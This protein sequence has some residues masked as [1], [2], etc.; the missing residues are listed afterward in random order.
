MQGTG[1][2]FSR[3]NRIKVRKETMLEKIGLPPKPSSRGNNW[4]VDASHCQGCSSLF[5]FINRKHHCRRCGGIF[6]NSCTQQRMVL[7][8]QGDSPVRICE[9]CKKLEEAARFEMRY[10]HKNRAGRGSSK[11]TMKHEDDDADQV[12]GS[13]IMGSSSARRREIHRSQSIEEIRNIQNEV[14]SV[15]PEELR[16]KAL[17]EKKKYKVLKGEGKSDEALKTFKRGKELERQ[18]EALEIA[19]RKN[20]KRALTSGSMAE[21]QNKDKESGRRSKLFP[22]VGKEKDDFA[23]ELR[24]LGWSDM[25]IHDEAKKPASSCLEGELSS[26][27]GEVSQRT[28]KNIGHHGIDNSQVVAHKKKALTLKREGKLAEAKEELKKAKV[29]EKQLEEQELL[30]AAEDSDD[31][32]SA[33]I[34]GMDDDKPYDLSLQY[35]GEHNYDLDHLVGKIDDFGVDANFEV[36]DN[37]MVDPEIAAALKSFGWTEDSNLRENMSASIDWETLSSEIQSL[38]REA[39]NQKRAGN[40]SEAVALLKKA[41]LLKK[42][43]ENLSPETSMLLK[44]AKVVNSEVNAKKEVGPKP[45]PKSRAVIQR[46]LLALKRKALALKRE[47]RLDE[48]EKELEK[49]RVLEHQLEEMDNALNVKS[50]SVTVGSKD[51]DF[52]YEHPDISVNLLVG[53]GALDVTDQEMHD[54]A[55]LSALESLGWNDEDSKLVDH[56]VKPR[57]QGDDHSDQT[58]ETSKANTAPSIPTVVSKR[59]KAE[60]Q[61][62]LLGLKRKALALRREGKSDEAEE[63]LTLAKALEA[64][65]AEM[66]AMKNFQSDS[67]WQKDKFINPAVETAIDDGDKENIVTEA[68]MHDP[69][70][71]S[72][73]KDLGWDDDLEPVTLQKVPANQVAV[74]STHSMDSSVPSKSK[75]EIQ[76]ELLDLKRRA[77]VHRRKGNTE[78]AEELLKMAKVLEAQMA[79]IE[80]PKNEI[81]VNASRYEKSGNNES[82]ISHETHSTLSDKVGIDNIS[83]LAGGV[84]DISSESLLDLGRQETH[85]VNSPLGTSGTSIQGTLQPTDDNHSLLGENYKCGEMSVLVDVGSAEVT[86]SHPSC[87]SVKM[88]ELLTSDDLMSFQIPAGKDRGNFGSAASPLAA[89]QTQS[90]SVASSKEDTKFNNVLATKEKEVAQGDENVNEHKASSINRF[91]PQTNQDSMRQEVLGHKR[92]AVALKREGKLIEAREELRQAKLLEKSLEEDSLQQKTGG[93]D[94]SVSAS[95]P[96]VPSTGQKESLASN[97]AGR[98]LSGRDRY[99]LQQQS[100]SHKRQALKLRREGRLQEAETEFELAK[101]LEAQLDELGNHSSKSSASVPEM[102]DV[103]IEDLLDPQLLSALKAIGLDEANMISQSPEKPAAGKHEP[104]TRGDCSQERIQLEERIKAEK[105]KA[106]NLKRSGKQAEALDALRRAK[107]YEKKLNLLGDT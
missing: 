69:G 4:V 15:S 38:K 102:V 11:L 104:V 40:V 101:A 9:P 56:S 64:Q 28:N 107:L 82:F 35:E 88:M 41:K 53:E 89:L 33:I 78:E 12:L 20:H 83:S 16:Q 19:I 7:R 76:R 74:N 10:G 25:D 39:L 84:R 65:M 46:E 3:K 90:V 91:T 75:G 97:S 55:Y 42:D 100:L 85:K 13:E 22:Q 21:I 59:S 58:S 8:G 51:P 31:E 72:V 30:G 95:A 23:A 27:L 52:F 63:L 32:L 73:L 66:G 36:T 86:R 45:V 37:D 103:V 61:R 34:S 29:L 79:E 106:V 60:I 2:R 57:K 44:S 14:G 17:E 94:V 105:V 68:D 6:C 96:G 71:L 77:L 43:L 99:K 93:Q 18:A 80:V 47:G 26:L 87:Q 98:P 70:L 62:E 54:P 50:A 49:G 67:G 81:L 92:K 5:T 48:A 1:F 24:D